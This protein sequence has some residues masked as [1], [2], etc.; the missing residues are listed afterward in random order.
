MP[1]KTKQL[2][3]CIDAISVLT[4]PRTEPIET[5]NHIKRIS[6]SLG[7]NINTEKAKV[8][9]STADKNISIQGLTNDKLAAVYQ[10]MNLGE[11]IPRGFKEVR[12]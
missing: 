5:Y 3:T 1:H 11:E 8:M 7:R 4:R 2:V 10:F 9:Q 6:K 12:E